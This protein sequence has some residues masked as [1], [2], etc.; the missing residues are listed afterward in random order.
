MAGLK[1]RRTQMAGAL[2]GI[3]KIEL[4]G[5]GRGPFAGMMLAEQGAR[6][7]RTQTPEPPVRIPGA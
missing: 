7:I 6:V 5:I 4:A 3:A 1:R 2:G